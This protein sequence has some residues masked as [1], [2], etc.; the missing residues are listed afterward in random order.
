MGKRGA[1]QKFADDACHNESCR[2]HPVIGKGSVVDNGT[3]QLDDKY[4]RRYLC[5]SCGGAFCDRTN[6][7]YYGLHTNEDKI[8]LVLKMS[9]NK[10][11]NEAIA[12]VLEVQPITVRGS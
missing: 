3:Y 8:D 6:T 11:S 7:V 2:D 12:Y 10:M 5:C 1:K 4:I 9:I